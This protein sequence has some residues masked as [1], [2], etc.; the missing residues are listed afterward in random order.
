MCARYARGASQRWF[1]RFAYLEAPSSTATTAGAARLP[2][3][4][5]LSTFSKELHSSY[6]SAKASFAAPSY[7]CALTGGPATGLALHVLGDST[8]ELQYT[9]CCASVLHDVSP[10]V[11]ICHYPP[12]SDVPSDCTSC[13]MSDMDVRLQH[14]PRTSPDPALPWLLLACRE[15]TPKLPRL[16]HMSELTRFESRLL[17]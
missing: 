9:F 6:S 4:T 12:P 2:S 11:S 16:R 7:P 5:A 13:S 3:I 15:A 10:S 1:V 17:Q 14:R 8:P